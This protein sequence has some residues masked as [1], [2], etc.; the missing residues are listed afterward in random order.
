M[1]VTREEEAWDGGKGGGVPKSV[2]AL[3]ADLNQVL[4]CACAKRDCRTRLWMVAW[5]LSADQSY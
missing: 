4:S 3:S 5:E 1:H 2:W